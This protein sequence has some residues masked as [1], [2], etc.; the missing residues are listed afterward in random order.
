MDGESVCR[1]LEWDSAFF[2]VRIARLVPS[3]LTSIIV[4]QACNWCQDNEIECL[5]FLAASDHAESVRLA[6]QSR[7]SLV[8]IRMTFEREVSN[9]NTSATQALPEASI[10]PSRPDDLPSLRTIARS[11]YHDS[12]FYYDSHFPKERAAALYAAWIEESCAGYADH[13]LVLERSG[14][15]AGY[16]TCHLSDLHIGAIGLVG[17][18]P[19]AQG[20]GAGRALVYAALRWFAGCGVE[21]VE[22]VTQGRNCRAQRLY[23]RCQFLS[24]SVELWYHKWFTT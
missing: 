5:Y 24:R 11:I 6:E 14:E 4:R 17:V 7:F 23:Q 3:R 19:S 16:V 8:D 21:R 15:P 18:H 9:I 20:I 13:V 1:F 10:R 2:G 22:V 12:R